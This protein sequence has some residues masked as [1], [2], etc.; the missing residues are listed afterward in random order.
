MISIIIPTLN[1]A[2]NIARLLPYL[3]NCCEGNEYEIIVSDCGST[4]GTRSIA[5]KNGANVVLSS[6]K[7]RAMQMNS[8]AAI[9]KFS[10]LYFVHADSL[11]PETFFKDISNAIENGYDIGRYRTKFE[12]GILLLKINAYFTRFDWFMCY[13]GDQTLFVCKWL[14]MTVNGFNSTMQIMEEYDLVKR[15]RLYGR[16]K[17]FEKTALVS[18]RKYKANNWFRVQRANYIALKMYKNK[19]PQ[20]EIVERYSYL[21]KGSKK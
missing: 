10:V 11:P 14:F 6:C 21:L 15:A 9:A 16:Y 5:E 2:E 7:G 19:R 13:G 8:G 3:K 17:I 12:G 20:Q 1:E 4:D 18:T